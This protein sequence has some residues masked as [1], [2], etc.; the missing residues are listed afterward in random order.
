MGRDFTPAELYMADKAMK[1]TSGV[2][3]RERTITMHAADGTVVPL[4]NK[5]AQKAY[6]ELSFLFD[7]FK[8]LYEKYENNATAHKVFKQIE[9]I[10]V[11]VE[12]QFERN[13][14]YCVSEPHGKSME[15]PV[16]QEDIS[17]VQAWFFGNLD[18]NFYYA[19]ENNA[20]FYTYIENRINATKR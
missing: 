11:S 8:I 18:A 9:T 12:Q 10:L 20:R 14:A 17:V 19:E 5:K 1:Q 13:K 15:N 4:T 7:S 2:A 3:L 16:V 6:P